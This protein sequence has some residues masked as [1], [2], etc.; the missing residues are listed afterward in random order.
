MINAY[1]GTTPVSRDDF[2]A[3]YTAESAGCASPK[4]KY[5]SF[6]KTGSGRTENREAE[7]REFFLLRASTHRCALVLQRRLANL[8]AQA[9]LLLHPAKTPLFLN[10]SYVCPKP[11]LAKPWFSA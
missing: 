1:I 10:F 9:Q 3:G 8:H 6:A 11:V 5:A 7:P 4:G 2:Q